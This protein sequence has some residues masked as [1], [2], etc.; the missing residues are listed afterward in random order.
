MVQQLLLLMDMRTR[1]CA[2]LTLG[3]YWESKRLILRL[4]DTFF[5][6]PPP[7][8]VC[9]I[10]NDSLVSFASQSHVEEILLCGWKMWEDHVWTGVGK[11][12]RVSLASCA[13]SEPIIT[14]TTFPTVSGV[15]STSALVFV[16]LLEDSQD[17]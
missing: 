15:V 8:G 13:E 4:K 6:T 14:A 2:K 10:F 12:E 11:V 1:R 7:F 9:E 5:A 3:S 16:V 17:R